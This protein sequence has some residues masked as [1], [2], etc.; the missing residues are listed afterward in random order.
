MQARGERFGEPRLVT[1]GN[2]TLLLFGRG[3][4]KWQQLLACGK[5]SL[6]S[7]TESFWIC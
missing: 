1:T 2:V 5:S 7:A 4:F 6:K 3:S